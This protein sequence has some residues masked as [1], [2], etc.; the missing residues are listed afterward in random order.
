MS[1]T[2]HSSVLNSSFDID[3][4]PLQYDRAGA[5]GAAAPVLVLPAATA[6]LFPL[7]HG[8]PIHT[9]GPMIQL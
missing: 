3:E 2:F 5:A 6:T 9:Q 7:L 1:L 4:L 8:S